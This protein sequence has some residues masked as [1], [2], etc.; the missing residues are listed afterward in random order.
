MKS[1]IRILGLC[2]MAAAGGA[3]NLLLAS[4]PLVEARELFDSHRYGAARRALEPAVGSSSSPEARLLMASICNRLE[5]WECGLLHAESA[6][7]SLP[8][9]SRAQFEYALA[10]RIRMSE[11]NKMKAMFSLGDYKDALARS[12]EL[13]ASNLD[14][15]EEE[16]GFLINAPGF[17]GRDL[18]R[19]RERIAEL[20]ALDWL[21]GARLRAELALEEDQQDE[22]ERIFARI[23]ERY[24]QDASTRL[25]VGFRRLAEKRWQEADEQFAAVPGDAEP[26]HRLAAL[27]QRGRTRVLGSYE[28]ERAVELFGEYIRSLDGDLLDL[29]SRSDAYWRQGLAYEQLGR[30]GAAKAAYREALR[31]DS[32]HKQSKQALRKLGG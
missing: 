9:S 32:S 18:D 14:A 26:R 7:A 17:A 28:A 4:E 1:R 6:A 11:V 16:V 13:D 24:P 20:E 10:L 5:D 29:P 23:L 25:F 2:L 27:Y 22:A 8:E 3:P 12:I 19:A 31:L 30:A 21:R 15:R